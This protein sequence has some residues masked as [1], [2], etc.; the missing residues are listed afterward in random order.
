MQIFSYY[1][2]DLNSHRVHLRHNLPWMLCADCDV[3]IYFPQYI[4]EVCSIG[5]A[6][7]LL[8]SISEHPFPVSLLHRC[9]HV[10]TNVWFYFLVKHPILFLYFAF[11]RWL[12]MLTWFLIYLCICISSF[13]FFPA[14]LSILIYSLCLIHIYVI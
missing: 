12:V 9:H 2:M 4:A 3:C 8:N 10:K 5:T 1:A 14:Y 6:A 7:W 11:L 13:G